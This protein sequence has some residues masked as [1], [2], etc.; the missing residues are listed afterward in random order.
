MFE[1]MIISN[2]TMRPAD[3]IPTFA[4]TAR[5]ML[6]NVPHPIEFMERG[7]AIRDLVIEAESLDDFDNENAYWILDDLFD[8]LD[9]LAP[10][11]FYFGALEGDGACYGYWRIEMD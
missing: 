5:W 3:L 6:C 8:A 4:S 2:G 7:S 1:P 10:E 9:D 11:G